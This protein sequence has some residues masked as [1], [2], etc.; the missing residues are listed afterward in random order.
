MRSR[1]VLALA[2]FAASGAPAA[3]R[4]EPK[5]ESI[6]RRPTPSWFEDAKLGIFIHWGVYAV[7]SFAPR[8]EVSTYARYS[9]WYWKRLVTPDMEGHKE[10][11][12][13]HDRVYGPGARYQDFAP[14]W[15]AELYDPAEWADVFERAGAKYVVL[16]SKHHDG[17][18]W[19]SRRAGTGRGGRGA[20]SMRP[21]TREG[22]QGGLK[23]GLLQLYEW[24]NPLYHED[25]SRYVDTA[26]PR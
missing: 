9:E 25:V 6:D 19:P 23:M 24:M 14:Q 20:A 18:A 22:R 21:A 2:V 16:T 10:F 4:V 11:K 13:F 5:W 12:A 17:F 3:E 7:P 26:V 1:A 15:K 8:T